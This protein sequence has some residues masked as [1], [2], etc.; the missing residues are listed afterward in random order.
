MPLDI[1]ALISAHAGE[2]S[3]L[4]EAHV[5]PRLAK[6][7]RLIGFDRSYVK[8]SGPYLW[9]GKGRRYLD[10]LAGYGVFNT[11]RNHPA[12]RKALIDFMMA[13]A[14]SLVQMETPALCGLLAR[15]LKRRCER[16]LERVYFC[17]AG[18]EATETAMKFARRAT[19][20]SHILYASRAFHG[21]TTGALSV[22]GGEVFRDGFGPLPFT[23]RVPFGDLEALDLAL[24][25]G[26]VAAFIVE[27]IQGK[28]VHIAPPGY[29]AEATRLCRRHGALLVCDEV[30][31]GMG[32][33]GRFLALHH[34]GAVEPDMILLSKALSGGYVPL[35]AVLMQRSIF[36][37]V[38]TSVD[39]AVVHSSTFGKSSF[40]M[41]AGLA[42]LSVMDEEDLM[43]NAARLGNRLGEGLVAIAARHEFIQD[44]RWRGLMLGIEFGRPRSLK[45][46]TAWN[47]VNA[48]NEDLFCQAVTI[49]LLEDHGILTQVAGNR[50]PTI[51]LI[52]PLVITAAD[53]DAFL[54]AFD[55]VMTSLH[56]FPGP[57][58]E[59]LFRIGRNVLSST[60]S[61]K[62]KATA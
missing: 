57:A 41:T 50:M 16:D 17:S 42:T 23:S 5:N 62:R 28:G 11:G 9:D 32:R 54:A 3:A 18:A 43:G 47:A 56:G 38:F 40:A 52:P 48:L 13:D 25:D 31:C 55:A 29:L 6:A 36:D 37:A 45:L 58:W 1:R 33:T 10:M 2:A 39:R 15:E 61:P 22:N 12:I 14:V 51:K 7:L 27:P 60:S 46:R 44:V 24:S 30:Q 26:D 8:A 4:Y 20:R 49:P 59:S 53:V 21:L 35:A 19:G 34:D